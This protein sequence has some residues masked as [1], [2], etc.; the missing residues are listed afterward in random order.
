MGVMQQQAKECQ[1]WPAAT[2]SWNGL[3][4]I[5]PQSLQKKKTNFIT[6]LILDC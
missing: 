5:L 3:E 4:H 1:G 2:G 6:T